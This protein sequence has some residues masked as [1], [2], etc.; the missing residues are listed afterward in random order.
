MNPI[1]KKVR[2]L[3]VE[4]QRIIALDL[5]TTINRIGHEVV[6]I[7]T[8]GERAVDAAESLRPD[9]IFMDISLAGEI[10]GIEA[11]RIINERFNIPVVYISGNH[12]E[13]TIEKS[14]AASAYGYLVKPVEDSDINTI[15]N[16]TIYRHDTESK[17]N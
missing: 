17:N 14:K 11:A 2:I 16:A 8:K 4:D 13:N 10:D 6:G 3:V 5:A 12:D 1:S 7:E 9:L 15:I